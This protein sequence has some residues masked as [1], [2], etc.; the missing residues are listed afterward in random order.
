[1][2]VGND[3][4]MFLMKIFGL[5]LKF[6][7]LKVYT[8]FC[9]YLL[10]CVTIG[11]NSYSHTTQW[12]D[13]FNQPVYML[14]LVAALLSCLSAAYVLVCYVLVCMSYKTRIVG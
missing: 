3:N 10:F 8:C 1:M 2:Y 4:F 6:L 14:T 12:K 9:K 5:R 13:Y 7:V 11:L